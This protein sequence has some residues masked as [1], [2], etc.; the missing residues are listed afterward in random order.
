[1]IYLLLVAGLAC[2]FGGCAALYFASPN[3]RLLPR[4]W[5]PVVGCGLGLALALLGLMALLGAMRPLGASFT[6]V[7]TAMLALVLLPY[8]G[9]WASLRRGQGS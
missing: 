5:S 4:P 1:M 3:Q 8:L 2:A 9:A 6:F 7:I